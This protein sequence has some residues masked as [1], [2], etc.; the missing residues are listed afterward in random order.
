MGIITM[1]IA[2]LEEELYAFNTGPGDPAKNNNIYESEDVS[3]ITGSTVNSSDLD[4]S[5]MMFDNNNNTNTTDTGKER[6][7]VSVYIC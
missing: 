1:Y 4:A 5:P 2:R 7:C 3:K 6:G